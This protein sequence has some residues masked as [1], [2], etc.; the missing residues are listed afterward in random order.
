MMKTFADRVKKVVKKI[1]A[2]ETLSYAA[3]ARAAGRPRAYRAVGQ[4]LKQNYDPAVPCHRVIR[5]G[6]QIGG[7]N[8]GATKKRAWLQKEARESRMSY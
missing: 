2:G 4:I 1:S 8:R 7:Y 6:G 5:S 3:V